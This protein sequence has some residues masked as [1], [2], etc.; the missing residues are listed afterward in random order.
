MLW[1][2]HNV[3]SINQNMVLVKWRKIED[4][5][6]LISTEGTVAPDVCSAE[7]AVFLA[8]ICSLKTENKDLLIVSS[9]LFPFS[10]PRI[11]TIHYS[12][13]KVLTFVNFSSKDKFVYPCRFYPYIFTDSTLELLTDAVGQLPPDMFFLLDFSREC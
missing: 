12:R 11:L 8:N 7:F 2:N 10:L 9:N 13:S 1:N 4:T 6:W 3:I 5:K